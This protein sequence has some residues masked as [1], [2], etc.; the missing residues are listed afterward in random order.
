MLC[1]FCFFGI[2]FVEFWLML[3]VQACGLGLDRLSLRALRLGLQFEAWLLQHLLFV[4]LLLAY[5]TGLVV[6]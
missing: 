6:C 1:A 3:L 2:G 4:C 5:G